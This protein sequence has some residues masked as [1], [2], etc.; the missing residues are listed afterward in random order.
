MTTVDWM[1]L[2]NRDEDL[3]KDL[4]PYVSNGPVGNQMIHHPLI[5]ELFYQPGKCALINESYKHKKQLAEQYIAEKKWPNYIWLTERPYRLDALLMCQCLGLFGIEYWRQ[6]G[7]VWSDTENIWQNLTRW[8]HIW[9]NE[10]S[11][12]HHCM[13]EEE[14]AALAMLPDEI[15]VYRGFKFKRA[16]QSLSWTLDHDKAKWFARRLLTKRQ[17]P[18]VA[19]GI[20]K[21]SDVL[22]HFLGRNESEIVSMKVQVHDIE[23][24]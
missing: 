16:C 23:R 4:E 11:L 13:D 7:N 5:I 24:I 15:P 9:S 2:A 21:K 18:Q 19:H 12:R 6:V 20:V 8:K 22:A 1:E 10:S 3:I 14:R 17:K